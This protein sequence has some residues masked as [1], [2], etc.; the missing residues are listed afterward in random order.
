MDTKNFLQKLTDEFTSLHT[1]KEDLFWVTYMGIKAQHDELV[2]AEKAMNRFKHNAVY[3]KEARQLA[4]RE[5]TGSE[6]H[7]ILNGWIRFFEKNQIE[8]EEAKTLLNEIIELENSIQ[9]K[10][11]DHIFGYIDPDT[12]TFCEASSNV[13][14]VMLSS[15]KSEARRK[16][17]YEGMLTIEQFVLENDYIPLIKLRNRFAR[18]LGYS[19]FMDYKCLYSE[20]MS[21]EE[22]FSLIFDAVNGVKESWSRHIAELQSQY[23][24]NVTKPWNF[25]FTTTGDL[26]HETDPYFPFADAMRRWTASFE[27]LG[28]DYQGASLTLD[29]LDR[30]GKYEN[31]F[32]HGPISAYHHDGHWT[33]SRINFTS[34][35]NPTQVGSGLVA[36]NTLFHEGGH[37]AHFSN[38]KQPSPV[39]SHEFP[40][41][42]MSVAELQSMFLD[43]F[44]GDPEWQIR[45]ANN[46]AGTIIPMNLIEKGI[47]LKQPLQPVGILSTALV[48][49]FEKSIHELPDSD[50]T[51]N[52]ICRIARSV[53]RKTIGF[54]SPRPVISIPHLL[55][56][57]SSCSYHGYLI[58]LIGVAQTRRHLFDKLGYMTDNPKVGELLTRHYW[59]PGN[60]Q[61]LK[62]LIHSMTGK[63]LSAHSLIESATMSTEKKMKIAK[64]RIAHIQSLPAPKLKGSMNCSIRIVHGN[65]LI[66][67]NS[68]DNFTMSE[69]FAKWISN[70]YSS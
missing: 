49:L 39:F 45:Y 53:E 38:I 24:Q 36:L 46:S 17:A 48:S 70:H 59:Q 18:S 20:D 52:T 62:S 65:E 41:L 29:L 26:N 64:S 68:V 1:Q 3:L 28:I 31:G 66:A 47:R 9:S 4:E 58:A 30:T 55:G 14:S 43:S 8:S 37:A 16:A 27:A 10:R 42:T 69:H 11:K 50:L 60:T 33:P 63:N 35:A 23:G 67:D 54:E 32:M 40:P 5:S 15:E 19:D 51:A 12:N 34:T 44:I 22:V 21:K 13:M 61:P 25:R 57:D 2:K 56:F 6:A 7:F